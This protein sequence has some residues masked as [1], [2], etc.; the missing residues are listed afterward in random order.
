MPAELTPLAQGVFAWLQAPPG[1]GR[2]NAGVVV[3]SDGLTLIDT[4]M[5][6]SQVE[7]FVDAVA[8]LESPV[9]RVV[10]TSSL[11]PFVGGS[12][13]FQQAAFYGSAHTSELLDLPANVAGYRRLHPDY[14]A[15]FDE[16][17]TTR[18]ISHVVDAAVALTSAVEVVP[19][20][21]PSPGNLVVLVPGAGI[22]FAG[23]LCSF[24]ATPLGFRPTSKPG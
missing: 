11:I 4:L 2:A 19:V 17:L 16:D 5:V 7:P 24:G 10:L 23:E 14:A 8:A 20:D 13:S 1:H 12:A 9:P 21:G 15:E 18:P 6:P 3:D 22:C